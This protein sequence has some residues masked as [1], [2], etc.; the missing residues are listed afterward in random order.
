[1]RK[2]TLLI[3]F[4]CIFV[5]SN[6][7]DAGSVNMLSKRGEF[8][9]P[10]AGN[11]GLSIDAIPIVNYFGNA[12]N[13]NAFNS[14]AFNF[15]DGANT[16]VGR[17]ML[18]ESARVRVKF[19]YGKGRIKDVE[20]ITK[21]SLPVSDPMVKVEDIEKLYFSNLTFAIGYEKTRGKGRVQG[22]Y[23]GELF[24]QSLRKH[25]NYEYGNQMTS[26]FTSPT[27]TNF[28]TNVTLD[29]F[30]NLKSRV[31]ETKGDNTFRFG[32]RGFIGV[33]YF[34]TPKIS[35][36]GEFGWGPGIAKSSDLTKT[37]EYWDGLEVK[38]QE[39][40]V[41]GGS[42]WTIDTDDSTGGVFLTFYF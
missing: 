18:D 26:D 31:L 17:Y 15:V 42:V 8:I 33:E 27:T 16:I 7:Q 2:F 24:I 37:E 34:F 21:D 13:G 12:A 23:G 11:I 5:Y 1:M 40:K 41:A 32:L 36:G 9:L 22:Y 39:T 14:G 28:G 3:L 30:G 19:R 6:A 29:P 10:E 25:S 35:I 20:Y 4:C 38:T